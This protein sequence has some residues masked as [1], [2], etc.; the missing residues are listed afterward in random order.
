MKNCSILLIFISVS[1][2]VHKLSGQERDMQTWLTAEI[3]IPVMNKVE[4][5]FENEMRFINNTS[6]LGRNQS[7]FELYYL[8]ENKWSFGIGYRLKTEF[9]FSNYKQYE[10]RWL[11]D[12]IWKTRIR[13]VR[14]NTRF[15]IQNDQE[16]FMSEPNSDLIHR[17]KIRIAYKIR[18][19]P[20]LIYTGAETY[21]RINSNNLF[22]LRKLRNFVGTRVDVS[23]Q[24]RVTLDIIID[25]EFNRITPFTAFI[26]QIG[27]SLDLGKMKDG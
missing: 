18:K 4:F 20:F 11:A 23:T 3:T 14:I 17:E 6:L 9:P 5:G 13:R 21:F 10:H 8:P 2:L 1:L 7:E 12:V 25:K 16:S 27:Y 24:S 22:E 19:T 26:L 15:R